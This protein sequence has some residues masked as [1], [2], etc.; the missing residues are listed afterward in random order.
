MTERIDVGILCRID[1][2]FRRGLIT[3]DTLGDLIGNLEVGL[4]IHHRHMQI[5][6][7]VV[8]SRVDIVER[9]LVE[10]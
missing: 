1:D 3:D 4:H 5:V 9:Q 6:G 7:I 2:D 10:Q 8:E